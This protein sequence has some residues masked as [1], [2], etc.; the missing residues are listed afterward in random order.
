MVKDRVQALQELVSSFSFASMLMTHW[1][2]TDVR[3]VHEETLASVEKL[4]STND[5]ISQE[6]ARVIAG[7]REQ[8][9]GAERLLAS[10]QT[11]LDQ[12]RLR[13][14]SLQDQNFELMRNAE[15]REL[16]VRQANE[17]W[18]SVELKMESLVA[19]FSNTAASIQKT[20]TETAASDMPGE[21]CGDANTVDE[22][23]A[24][25]QSLYEEVAILTERN[26]ELEEMAANIVE[27][28]KIGELVRAV[29]LS[30]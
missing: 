10:A 5:A 25:L 4:R 13:I 1:I 23:K 9:A 8:L 24:Q 22:T 27:R 16:E 19:A 7:L 20:A 17:R 14:Q 11:E 18:N 12:N 15:G 6:H 29:F 26:S 2:Q 21:G 28:Y 30:M 3:S